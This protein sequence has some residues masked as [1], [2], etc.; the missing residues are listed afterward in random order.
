MS[1]RPLRKPFCL[2]RLCL[3]ITLLSV[4][5]TV[6]AILPTRPASAQDWL[7][8]ENDMIEIEYL[9]P[10][11]PANWA[12][13]TL[14]KKRRVLEELSAFLS[15]LRLPRKLHIVMSDCMA[16]NA[17]YS[18]GWG[19]RVCY[20]LPAQASTVAFGMIRRGFTRDDVIVGT[21][22]L[23]AL[24]EIG[25]AVFDMLRV[26]VFGR[27][28]DAADQISAL[29][30]LYF[31]T[32]VARRTITGYAHFFRAMDR[33]L[34]R[35]AFADEHGTHLQRFY[36]LLCIAYGAQPDTFKNIIATGILPQERAA[37]C[38]DEYEQVRFAFSQTI[39][40][41]I[42]Q[43]RLNKVRTIAWARWEGAGIDDLLSDFR[44]RI[45]LVLSGVAAL[46][47]Y[48]SSTSPKALIGVLTKFDRT[49]YQGRIGRLHWWTYTIAIM[50]AENLIYSL[51]FFAD[52]FEWPLGFQIVFVA[53][54]YALYGTLYWYAIFSI[55]RLHDRNRPGWQVV[56][57]FAPW[58]V[59]RVAD[60]LQRMA[61]DRFE[62]L[63]VYIGIASVLSA[64]FWLWMFVGLGL[65]RGTPGV[66]RFGPEDQYSP[67][68]VN[69]RELARA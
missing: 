41:H 10:F 48:A 31:G 47:L 23:A 69:V 30:M 9:V 67:P 5:V 1:R 62:S 25:H 2:S 37:R 58:I 61:P 51:L 3:S 60:T 42:D 11:N 8:L 35:T 34:S 18:S 49:S 20:E 36:N 14:A 43:D 32:D 15:P 4:L 68:E 55:K 57:W 64:G 52:R 12:T 7:G 29:V 53:L 13:Y 33:P 54:S 22:V 44:F 28:E 59:Y 46:L 27:E 17:Y 21:F 65:R 56:F 39:W 6:G 63:A 40:P 50:A 45:A 19:V 16:P 66:N 38:G 24:H 26:P